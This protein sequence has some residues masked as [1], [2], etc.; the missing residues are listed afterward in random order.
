VETVHSADGT[1]LAVQQSGNGDPVI[2]VHGSAGGL[3]SWDPIVPMLTADFEVWVY[4]R[5]GYSPRDP[6]PD[7]KS[8]TDD[9]ADLSAVIAAAGGAA[10]MVGASYGAT[11]VLHAALQGLDGLR[12]LVVFE[13]PLYSA[14]AAVQ[15]VLTEYDRLLSEGAPA[16]AARLFAERVARIPRALLDALGPQEP[17]PAELAG[18]RSDL[19]AMAADTLDLQRW[20]AITQPLLL[21][22][23][24][25]TWE[26]MPDTMRALAHAL[27]SAEHVRL[28]GQSH[29]A[30]HTAPQQFAD[31]VLSH[32]RAGAPDGGP[33]AS[34]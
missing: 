29:F 7:Q 17:D 22:S 19:E 24:A 2:L 8:F 13:P 32:L 6:A 4:A 9:V 27:P 16:A 18:C 3:D 12:S 31:A 20:S 10:H 14:G 25:D 33:A 15:P 26:P 30:T 5:R 21:L 1:R 23:G 34:A 28:A 11:V